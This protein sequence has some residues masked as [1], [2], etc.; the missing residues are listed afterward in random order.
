[1][2][3]FSLENKII[4]LTGATGL[5]G[6]QFAKT[7]IDNGAT[8]ILADINYQAALQQS[9]ELGNNSIPYNLDITDKENLIELKEFLMDKFGRIDVLINN[10][11]INE[12]VENPINK[13]EESKF[14]NYPLE[15]FRKVMDVNVTGVFLTCQIIGTEMA[16]HKNGNIINIASTYGIVTPNQSIYKDKSG[17]Q[18]FYKSCA[19][20]T[21]KAAVIQL[22]RF[23]AAYWGNCNVRVN[24]LSPGGVENKQDEAFINNYSKLTPLNR[25]AHPTDYNGAIVFLASD[26]S[27]YMTG[28]NLVVDGGWTIW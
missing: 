2:D 16:K 14:E 15:L 7:L 9:K 10:A 24:C 3:M 26:S 27:K 17:N 21:S 18:T 23:L 13:L 6:R 11:A 5:L 28:A 4:V 12:M 19:Y 22:T 8:V 25:M 1:M 20:P